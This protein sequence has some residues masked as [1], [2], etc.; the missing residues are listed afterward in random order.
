MKIGRNAQENWD[1][2]DQAVQTDWWFHLD[3][4][5]GPHVYLET[6]DETS[7]LLAAQAAKMFSK[8]KNWKDIKVVYTQRKNLK[9]GETVGEVYIQSLRKCKYI[10]V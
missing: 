4:F 2:L 7:L 9:R 6:L 10:V 5:P 1:L 8:Y 3:K